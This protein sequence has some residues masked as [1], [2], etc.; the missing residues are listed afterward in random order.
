MPQITQQTLK[1]TRSHSPADTEA[2]TLRAVV[3]GL[4]LVTLADLYIN[5]GTLLLRASKLNKSYFPMGLFFMFVV[6]LGVNALARRLGMR[7]V[8]SQGELHVV[9]GMGLIGSF[10]PFF[11]LAGF[12]VGVVAAPFYFATAENAWADLLHG[13]I[14]SWV[15][16]HNEDFAASWF[17]EGVPSTAS[18]PWGAWVSP[19]FWW[20][21]LV[22]AIGLTLLCA[23]VIMRKQWVEHERLEYPLVTVGMKMAASAQDD[24]GLAGMVR[25]RSFQVAFVIGF[26]AVGWN[27]MVYFLP[28]IP[29]LPTVPTSG[30]WFR[31]LERAPR[32]WVQIS[33]YIIGFAYFA[34]VE[35]L[36]SFWA[37]FLLTG[38]EIAVFDRLGVGSS[39]G[40]GGVEAVRSQSFGALCALA[41]ASLWTAR[42][43]IRSVLAKAFG[44]ASDIDDS[45]EALSYQTAVIGL[46][47]G[48][49]Y[50]AGWLHAAGMEVRVLGFY[51]LFAI[52][53]YLGLSRVVAEVGLPY[54]NISDTAV[55]W[56]AFYILGSKTVAAST[57]VC[58]GFIYALF[59]TTRGFLG[60]PIA[61]TLKLATS[62]RSGRGRLAGAIALALM[63]GFS[64]SVLHTIYLGYTHG[65]YNLGA[66]SLIR[67]S[68]NAYQNAVTWMRNPKPS[69]A[70]R[71]IFMGS[72]MLLTMALTYLKYRMIWWPLP[73]V[74]L[75]LQGM[76]MARRIVFPVFLVW[77]YKSLV[78]KVGGAQLYRKGQPFFIGL[79][80]GYAVAVFLSTA[81][82]HAFFWGRGHSVHDF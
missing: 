7:R 3:I 9:L 51:L 43:H 10:F 74:G 80:V 50:V 67:G 54:A 15:A 18:I 76:Y 25:L 65:G 31:W 37:F 34:R 41:L 5:W 2:V 64:V 68:Q 13:H 19:L 35:A 20:M 22:G 77:A 36:F 60:P 29:S 21:T 32:F 79:M 52:I 72:G 66:W 38:V 14:P 27:V 30:H 48:L 78:L 17:Y 33:I 28:M 59:A 70:D 46:V 69:D 16:L 71:L 53:A 8:L 73:P 75:A 1:A 23:M 47:V 49:L 6:L 82:D 81:V 24:G 39:V 55:N 61:Q 26:M 42:G 62:I 11:G 57:L 58:Q 4:A 12:L 40:Q 44:G 63:V 56:T 45:G